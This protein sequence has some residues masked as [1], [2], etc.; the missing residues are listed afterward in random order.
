MFG[1]TGSCRSLASFLRQTSHLAF[2]ACLL[3]RFLVAGKSTKNRSPAL[4]P[5]WRSLAECPNSKKSMGR[6]RI[7]R[8]HLSKR[9]LRCPEGRFS[10]RLGSRGPLTHRKQLLTSAVGSTSRRVTA[11][12]AWS[13]AT[14]ARAL[15]GSPDDGALCRGHLRAIILCK[16]RRLG[17]LVV[18]LG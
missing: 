11:A 10:S 4:N 13:G 2:E 7:V 17:L 15:L 8:K 16:A 14:S 18:S 1:I 3:Q 5:S 9:C 12:R 6:A